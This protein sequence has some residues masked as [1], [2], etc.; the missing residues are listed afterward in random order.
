MAWIWM[1]IIMFALVLLF[2][3]WMERNKSKKLPPGPKGFPIMGSL[4]LLGKLPHRDLHR[5]SQTY[6]PIM[7]MKLGIVN[8]IVVSSPEAAELFLKTHDVVF[9]SRAPN[10]V[11]KHVSFSQKTIAFAKYGPY[12]RNMRKM[13]ILELLS[14][15]KANYLQS[16]RRQELG[17]TI[18]QLRD[19]AKSGMVVNISSKIYSLTANMACLMIIGRRFEDKEL[20]EMGFKW[21]IQE[22]LHLAGAF[23]LGDFIPFI[24]PLDLQGF[25]RCARSVHKVCDTFFEKIL[26]EHLESNNNDTKD[27]VDVMLGIMGSQATE[28]QID[29]STIKAII[30]DMLLGGV[31]TS[32]TTIEWALAELVRHPQTMKKVQDELQKVVGLNRMVQEADLDHLEYLKMV[33]KETFRLH[34]PNP[35]L[36][37]RE[38]VKDSVINNFYIPQKSR[39]ILN[40]WAIGRDPSVWIDAEKFFP[41]R[42]IGTQVDVKGRDFQLLPF[43]SGR[44]GCPG[45]Q[46][47]L[48]TVHLILAQLVHCF[49]WKLPNGMLPDELDMTE[50][51]G[52][53]CPLAH[54]IMATPTY[55]LQD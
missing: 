26:D 4:H 31:E 16:M 14:N 44:R 13:C 21:M 38:S 3:A 7:H 2:W 19:A 28:Y 35:L 6:G 48:V 1:I 9:A 34:P 15:H 5:L 40:V 46:M 11:F 36:I 54:N 51:F 42:F 10:E 12:W 17:F 25:I 52:L 55:R 32:A 39:I 53:S 49:D 18:H 37:P 22:I 43:G 50:K 41:E 20:D 45:I 24:A 33:V 47:G 30:L 27:L 8:T 29:P 23:N